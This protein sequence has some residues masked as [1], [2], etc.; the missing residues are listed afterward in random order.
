MSGGPPEW[1]VEHR[2]LAYLRAVG[3]AGKKKNGKKGKTNKGYIKERYQKLRQVSKKGG[4][5]NAS[6]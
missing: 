4:S 1:L 5:S 3:N 6:P 2:E